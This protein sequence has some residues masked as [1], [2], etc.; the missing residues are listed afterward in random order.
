[1][2][3]ERKRPAKSQFV[4]VHVYIPH[5][6]YVYDADC[7]E[8]LLTGNYI[9]QAACSLRPI[10]RWLDFLKRE[11]RFSESTIII[12]GDHGMVGGGDGGVPSLQS[13]NLLKKI[14]KI[15]DKH[16]QNLHRWS[17]ALLLIKPPATFIALSE[18]LQ[19]SPRQTQNGDIVA[20]LAD[21]AGLDF[22]A[23][24]GIS[25]FNRDFP[26]NREVD[27]FHGYEQAIYT[28]VKRGSMKTIRG[29]LLHFKYNY[30]KGWRF[31]QDVA[32]V[33]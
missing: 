33:W 23:G 19:V 25:V 10:V 27:I 29:K 5:K 30:Q 21:V 1:M 11:E 4:Y 2:E 13:K 26:E 28:K 32:C 12:F 7:K 18:P 24:I 9:G 6:P 3:D 16:P 8:V 22:S 20:T 17:T 15:G 31:I 14:Q